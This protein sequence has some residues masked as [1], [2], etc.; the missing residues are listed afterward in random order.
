MKTLSRQS[1]PIEPPARGSSAFRFTP[2]LAVLLGCAPLCAP[3]TCP[4]AGK[5]FHRKSVN[6]QVQRTT[7]ANLPSPTAS[8]ASSPAI[9]TFNGGTPT[10]GPGPGYGAAANRNLKITD[11]G[12][13]DEGGNGLEQDVVV[14]ISETP[15]GAF[16]RFTNITIPAGTSAPLIDGFRYVPFSKAMFAG[17]SF[18]ISST[19]GNVPVTTNPNSLTIAPEVTITTD[20]NTAIGPNFRITSALLVN[21]DF[22]AGPFEAPGSVNGWSV[23]RND[24]QPGN[25]IDVTK[26]AG[27]STHAVVF[28]RGEDSEGNTLQQFFFSEP[29]RRYALDFDAAIYGQRTGDPLQLDVQVL[30]S[31]RTV[32]FN[33]LVAPPDAFT[34]D[35][36][37]VTF[38]HYHIEFVANDG[39]AFLQFT[40]VG[41]GNASADTYLDSVTLAPAPLEYSAWQSLYFSEAEKNDLSISGWT[42]DPDHDGIPNGLEFYFNTNPIAGMTEADAAALPRLIVDHVD[43]GDLSVSYRRRIGAGGKIISTNSLGSWPALQPSA[44][45]DQ[46]VPMDNVTEIVTA[47]YGASGGHFNRL[48]VSFEHPS[49]ATQWSS[50]A[51]GNDHWYEVITAPATWQAARDYA[52]DRGGYLA[53]ITSVEENNFI[54]SLIPDGANPFIGGYI[55]NAGPHWVTAEP[56]DFANWDPGEP[57]G[58]GADAIQFLRST[59]TWNDSLS[60]DTNA[61]VVEYPQ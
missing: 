35:F 59:G 29:N 55:D 43:V 53:T 17:D 6:R 15:G 58:P 57:N 11:I 8:A 36:N 10:T 18:V 26:G 20:N 30:R 12:V 60:T 42:A 14:T 45:V 46:T 56:F 27:G 9:V 3:V 37:A 23:F 50:S 52:V 54:Q 2:F 21:D 25:V 44:R 22:E 19:N 13:W 5:R 61:F 16:Q 4:A 32:S 40:D 47:A 51:G 1:N 7:S 24:S 39:S 48:T 28:N 41:L 38:Q 31:D 34:F 33:Q 49:T